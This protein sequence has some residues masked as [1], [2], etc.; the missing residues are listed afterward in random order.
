M[1]G[2]LLGFPTS[3]FQ[4]LVLLICILEPFAYQFRVPLLVLELLVDVDDVF[5]QPASSTMRYSL[6]MRAKKIILRLREVAF[7]TIHRGEQGRY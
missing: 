7:A 1:I 5:F 6:I 2:D 4:V 3:N